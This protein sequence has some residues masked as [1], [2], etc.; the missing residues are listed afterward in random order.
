MT[1]VLQDRIPYDVS[2]PRALPGLQ[3]MAL[4]DW[5]VADEAF[6]GQMAERERLL[7]TVRDR[8]VAL[9]ASAVEAAGELLDLVLELAYPDAQDSVLRPDGKRVTPDPGDPMGSLGRL[10]QE[11]FC[12]L[13]KQGAEHVLTGAV[14]CFPASW[15]LAEKFRRPLIAIHDPVDNYDAQMAR[16]VQRVFDGVQ[17]GRPMWRFNAL[18]YA[19]PA[20]FQ[21]RS[22]AEPRTPLRPDEAGYLRSERQCILR[23]P[24]TGAVVFSIHTYVLSRQGVDRPL[25]E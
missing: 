21:P 17:V 14:L 23:L 10:V 6:A 16:R 18:A 25:P 2:A 24:R 15:T 19:D 9:Q 5:L 11:D 8:V 7:D 13:Q 22:L 1:I 4:R 20:L 3:P 12:I